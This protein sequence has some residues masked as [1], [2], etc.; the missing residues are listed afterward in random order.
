MPDQQAKPSIFSF[1]SHSAM[2]LT[3]LII[4]AAM[5]SACGNSGGGRL[6]TVPSQ[7][8][9]G[10][11]DRIPEGGGYYKVGKPYVIAGRRYFPKED[12][13]YDRRGVASWYGTDFHG[14]KTANGEIFDM[15]R[16]SAAHRT[17]P[18]PSYA[19]VTNLNNGRTVMVR[20][21]DRGPYAHDREIDLSRRAA[22]ALGF[23]RQ[24][25]TQVRVQYIGPAPL[26]GD[27]DRLETANRDSGAGQPVRLT[28]RSERPRKPLYRRRAHS[29][30]AQAPIEGATGSTSGGYYVQAASFS[31]PQR[32]AQLKN[33]L[34]PI[35]KAEVAP[36]NMGY[37]TFYRVRFGPLRDEN[38][39]YVTLARVRAAGMN[40][41][42]IISN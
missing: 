41:A 30:P 24:G 36:T 29:T 33:R 16:M 17:M 25:T 14:R 42:R 13:H 6:G 37:A 31:D 7:Q 27:G 3:A 39:A 5:L 32:A 12:P 40:A 22:K 34:A 38:A 18:L 4:G 19:R 1:N 11:G 10:V 23:Q 20:V 26:E 15:N 35:G 8:V 28:Q 2:R 21:N 9:Y